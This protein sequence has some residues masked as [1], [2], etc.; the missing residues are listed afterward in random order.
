MSPYL[1]ALTERA[2]EIH[3]TIKLTPVQ[4]ISLGPSDSSRYITTA[5]SPAAQPPMQDQVFVS[6]PDKLALVKVL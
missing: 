4:T 2:I 3:D 1:V 5:G 6:S